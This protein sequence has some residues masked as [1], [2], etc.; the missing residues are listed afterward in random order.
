MATID[1][2]NFKVILDDKDFTEQ[3]RKD[4]ELSQRFNTSI[5]SSIDIRK[6]VNDSTKEQS[7]AQRQLNA[8]FKEYIQS[9]NS[10]N[11]G[12]KKMNQYYRELEKSSAKEAKAAL[13]EK[14]RIEAERA[15]NS[16][17]NLNAKFKALEDAAY[18]SR[19]EKI[20]LSH[21]IDQVKLSI[22][23]MEA[24]L[25]KLQSRYDS[26]TTAGQQSIARLQQQIEGARASIGAM[27]QAQSALNASYSN[28]GFL[29]NLRAITGEDMKHL[30]A[31][32]ELS[33]YYA[34]EEVRASKRKA[35]IEAA[36]ATEQK[37]LEVQKKASEAEAKQA[38]AA[39]KKAK[40]EERAAKAKEKSPGR[41]AHDNA[42][43]AAQEAAAKSKAAQEQEKLNLLQ[44]KSADYADRHTKTLVNQSAVMKQLVSLATRY[45]SVYGL[46]SFVKS[47]VRITGEFEV[48]HMALRTILGDAE[49]ADRIFANLKAF[50]VE[51][52]YTFQELAKYTKQLAAF[53]IP[54][55]NLL[56]TNKMLADVAA[57]LG[58][59]MDRLTQ[60][61][62]HVKS[63]GFLRGMQ[64]RQFTQNGVPILE[65]L[66]DILGEVEGRAIS[67]GQVFEKMTK[68]EITF[69][70]VEEAFRRMTSEGGKF[71]KMQ[72]VLVET[73]QGKIGK[74]KDVWQQT[75]NTFGESNSKL[76]KG[77]VDTLIELVRNMD[78]LLDSI[79]PLVAGLGSYATVLAVIAAKQKALALGTLARDAY[80]AAQG[81]NAM[82]KAWAVF[83]A[84]MGGA[85]FATAG[86]IAALVGL[87]TLIYRLSTQ[88]SVAQKYQLDL[89]NAMSMAEASAAK[90][91][92]TLDK[93]VL[94]MRRNGAETD[95]YKRARQEII[96]QFGQYD[97]NLVNEIDRIK[98]MSTEYAHLKE[99]IVAVSKKRMFDSFI[100]SQTESLTNAYNDALGKYIEKI[101]SS[102]FSDKGKRELL[103]LIN[104]YVFNGEELT[105]SQNYALSMMEA[106]KYLVE[107]RENWKQLT[108]VQK[109]AEIAF[110]NMNKKIKQSSET[111]LPE[112]QKRV[113]EAL[114]GIKY[115]L[116][117]KAQLA[118]KPDETYFEYLQR[119]GKEWQ[120]IR[121][122]RDLSLKVDKKQKQD[123]LDVIEIVNAA[124]EGNILKNAKYQ[125]TPWLADDDKAKKEVQRRVN[126]INVLNKLRDAYEKLTEYTDDAKAKSLMHSIFDES[127]WGRIDS[128]K[129]A[130]DEVTKLI[131]ELEGLD[132]NKAESLRAALGKDG[133]T[134]LIDTFKA[135]KQYQDFISKWQAQDFTL[136][137]R[138]FEFDVNKIVRDY[139]TA[140]AEVML[141]TDE[142]VRKA[143]DAYAN[144]PAGLEKQISLINQL[145]DAN[146]AYLKVL[147]QDKIDS[148]AKDYV[149]DAYSG[150]LVNLRNLGG[151]SMARLDDLIAK[152]KKL[153]D[154]VSGIIPEETLKALNAAGI[155]VEKLKKAVAALFQSD[156]NN[157]LDKKLTRVQTLA[158]TITKEIS[159][160]G[161][162]FAKIGGQDANGFMNQFNE[163]LS[164]MMEFSDIVT[165][166]LQS[167]ADVA[168]DAVE[169]TESV[170]EGSDSIAKSADVLTMAIKLVALF[171]KTIANAIS[172]TNE[173][174][175]AIEEAAEKARRANIEKSLSDGIKSIF[176]EDQYKSAQNAIKTLQDLEKEI[177]KIQSETSVGYLGK[178]HFW[179]GSVETNQIKKITE[180][181]KGLE[182]VWVRKKAGSILWDPE[183]ISLLDASKE[184]G[185]SLYDTF[186]HLNAELIDAILNTYKL[187][188]EEKE[189]F[190]TMKNN[191]ELYI[192]AVEQVEKVMS[193]LFGQIADQAA[194]KIIDSWIEAGRAALDYVDILDDVAKAYA[195]MVLKSAIMNKFFDDQKAQEVA[196]YFMKGED[197]KALAVIQNAMQGVADAAPV[198]EKILQAFDPYFKKGDES[199][200]SSLGES[201]K[202]SINEEQ[203]NLIASYV[204]AMRADLSFMRGKQTQY[205]DYM[206][207]AMPTLSEHVASIDAHTYDIMLSNAAIAESTAGA[208]AEMR[209]IIGSS[210]GLPA[211]RV[212]AVY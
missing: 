59:S 186:G 90:E 150:N 35:D 137:G 30:Q 148:L 163:I 49:K 113:N 55:E 70:M 165:D 174:S 132:P 17:A 159:S 210:T 73:L 202:N 125:K 116:S 83:S 122:E 63:S 168:S 92:N 81:A 76:L 120:D 9:M 4:I 194:D 34:E 38:Q 185:Y 119:I 190:E 201:I 78:K 155:D 205:I 153:K 2:L 139:N 209:S 177:E 31:Q 16:L 156:Y 130:I 64:L 124:L 118:I 89:S 86:I 96:N 115:E 107:A 74:L 46:T 52:P 7:S 109:Q 5:S 67:V 152:I 84:V 151:A 85:S 103:A 100:K 123:L 41:L 51:S 133:L 182:N 80:K 10:T 25:A 97:R 91:L 193:S 93:L 127:L 134:G 161:D 204:N 181:L 44:K 22:Q 56:S 36:F 175:H 61:Y 173:L 47:L 196:D 110:D 140:V 200:A 189:W 94:T 167:V 147:Q 88:S 164:F 206:L 178:F 72:E 126:E 66:A 157:L 48:Q 99:E 180:G 197:D 21:N 135:A 62:G 13:I 23:S 12:L 32:K 77:S 54:A 60:A 101:N 40:A 108:E 65:Q 8:E 27:E 143:K 192:K 154:G 131:N 102:Y 50:A 191:S 26:T 42:M 162:A 111:E 114:K 198:W 129:F 106:G 138:G 212:E 160:V 207:A 142:A 187:T 28:T 19:G 176:G 3:V 69:A 145:R 15:E 141:K 45:F 75:M 211:V 71:Y 121:E 128:N 117:S 98:D 170:S 136:S 57:G 146:I 158:K 43:Y 58:V 87:G 144:D 53:D 79:A 39:E 105:P 179:D 184:L 112:W 166:S 183:Y 95:E 6:R 169:A 24:E 11:D 188:N 104:S 68:R 203:A 172:G 195:K 1:N 199:G 14:I 208:L 171:A 33:A 37:E 29:E 149:K 82:A 18:S 20:N